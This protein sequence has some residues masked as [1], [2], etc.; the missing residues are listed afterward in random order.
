MARRPEVP[1]LA[2]HATIADFDSAPELELLSFVLC[3]LGTY[4]VPQLD[5]ALVTM[6]VRVPVKMEREE[7]IRPG[8]FRCRGLRGVD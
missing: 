5:S 4:G 3:T 6:S 2:A 8:D 7:W 1:A